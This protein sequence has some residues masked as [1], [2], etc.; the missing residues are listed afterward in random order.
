MKGITEERLKSIGSIMMNVIFENISIEHKF[1][2]VSDSFPIPSHGILGREFTKKHSCL[3]DYGNMTFTVRPDNVPPVSIIITSEIIKGL[4]VLPP[5]AETFKMFKINSQSFPCILESQQIA[6]KVFIPTTIIHNT[7]AWIRVLN[8]SEKYEFIDI[9]KIKISEL[10]NYDILRTTKWTETENRESELTDILDNRMPDHIRS[11]LLPLCKEFA[12]IFHLPG[13]KPT[14]NNFYSHKI[15][16]HD[17]TPVFVKNYR[18][19][20]SQKEEIR[21]QVDKL[22]KDELIEMSRSNYSSPLLVVP[23]KSTDGQK[24]WRLCVDYKQLNKKLIPDKFPLPRMD[25][26]LDSLGKAKYFSI[27]DL[28]AGYHQIPLDKESRPLTAFCTDRGFYQWKVLPFGLNI[29]PAS[30]T[31]M[32]TIAFSGLSPEQSFIYMDDL[33]VIGYSENHH[34]DNL[35]QVF[36]TCRKHNLK[37]NPNKCDFFRIEVQFLGHKCTKD[38]LKP[39]EN[40][41]NVVEKYV[42]PRDKKETKRFTAFANYYRRFIPNFAAIAKPLN[43]LTKKTTEFIWTQEC[44]NSFNKLKYALT[45][46]PVLAYPDFKKKFRITVDASMFACGAYISQENDGIDKP[47][48]YISRTFK[49]G[50]N[51]KPIIEKE[52]IAIHFAISQFRPYI[53]GRHFT[54]YSDH[55]PLIYLFKMK[56]PSS[57]LT[58]IRLD[59]EEYMFEIIHISGTANVV[60][61]ALSRIDIEDLKNQYDHEILAIT[62]SMTKS[63]RVDTDRTITD[64]D[65]T[66]EPNIFEQLNAGFTK[67]IPR[68]KTIRATTTKN[69]LRKLTLS[70]FRNHNKIC[71]CIF[72]AKPKENLSLR[73]IF[74]M[75]DSR[76]EQHN[77]KQV[78]WPL[79]DEIFKYFNVNDFKQSGVDNLHHVKI[80][81]IN[82]PQL[83]ESDTVKQEILNKYHNDKLFGGHCGQKRLYA[84]IRSKFYWP[85]MT[86]DVAKFVNNCHICKL[87]KPNKKTKE[88]LRLTETPQKPFDIVQI[89]TIGPMR[90]SNSGFGYAITMVCDLTKYLIAIPIIDKSAKSVAQAIFHEFVLKYGPM[91]SIRSDLGTEYVNEVIRELCTLLNIKHDKSTAYHH[92]TMGTVERNHRLLNEYLRAYLNGCLDEWD[93]YLQYFA[94]CYNTTPSTS[95]D[96]KYSPFE[97]IF[98]RRANMPHEIFANNQIEPVYNVDNYVKEIKHKLQI[99]HKETKGLIEKIKLRNKLN[100]DKNINRVEFNVGDK[101]KIQNEPYDKFKQI[102][103]GPFIITR[104]ENEN[105]FINLNGREYKIHKNRVL[106]YK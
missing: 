27:M 2:V 62:R 103:S 19:P 42:K 41:I 85:N 105:L 73:T 50:E 72:D 74:S 66:T 102:Y 81:L 45:H 61:D 84:K 29:A 3:I 100:Y 31:R 79:H 69:K 55:K 17:H 70:I 83:I 11:K 87:T 68:V 1:F 93:V 37:L 104:M 44:E 91:K 20:H 35:K 75:L 26:I 60:A 95:N 24:K 4:S 53:Y 6:E 77:I 16:A 36:E 28:Q 47:I 49:K 14:I 10:D 13:D 94:F 32:M 86:R 34:I 21:S 54:V 22:I 57:K 96:T 52:L 90:K 38:G 97:M 101:I 7:E 43:A 82:R 33:I 12:D 64:V 48:A 39:D 106:L 99:A 71:D 59:L 67:G 5:R 65:D 76:A 63:E 25:E 40:K 88:E 98:A 8:T 78:Q 30:F 18:L 58:R 89:D 15:I 23:K 9:S 51:N 56:N 46:A 92:Q 80:A